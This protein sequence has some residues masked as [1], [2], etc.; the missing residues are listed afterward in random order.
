[1]PSTKTHSHI[2][3]E[4]Q[5]T[6][7]LT[8]QIRLDYSSEF[9]SYFAVDSCSY[10]SAR[11][12]FILIDQSDN[13]EYTGDMVKFEE[14]YSLIVDTSSCDEALLEMTAVSDDEYCNSFFEG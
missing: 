10:C 2:F 1:M 9:A 5:S 4:S 3:T 8:S 6:S 13:S 11:K 12:N 14:D 7:G